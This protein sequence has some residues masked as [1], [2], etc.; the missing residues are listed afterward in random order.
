M[1]R[2]IHPLALLLFTPLFGA[3]CGKI[4][5]GES[6]TADSGET[7]GDI[8]TVA[9][10]FEATYDGTGEEELSDVTLAA[11]G[12]FLVAGHRSEDEFATTSSALFFK[13]D[14]HGVP[15][16]SHT[17][18]GSSSV[19][20]VAVARAAG[21]GAFLAGW[22]FAMGEGSSRD[23]F[24]TR[25]DE[26]GAELWQK[27]YGTDSG[28]EELNGV[29][30]TS[31]GGLLL[32]GTQMTGPTLFDAYV[33]RIDSSGEELF[34]TVLGGDWDDY[35]WDAVEEQDGSFV[36]VGYREDAV[37]AAHKG[38]IFKLDSAGE[39]QWERLHGG[40]NYDYAYSIT[41]TPDGGYAFSGASYS[42]TSEI[43]SDL[44]VVKTDDE[45]RE[46]WHR[47]VDLPFHQY[48]FGVVPDGDGGLVVGGIHLEQGN[49]VWEGLLVG[50]DS[51]GATSWSREVGGD[52][53]DSIYD[54]EV[55]G[56]SGFVAIGYS[57]SYSDPGGLDGWMLRM[58]LD[59]NP[60]SE[61]PEHHELP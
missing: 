30:A 33:V 4:S 40:Q 32:L 52:G 35:A 3:A 57:S 14:P 24:V 25:V 7:T 43:A 2:R 19:Y 28:D 17:V 18:E 22:G 1:N 27:A 10:T 41:A 12:G 56:E 46:L 31:D 36:V 11:D 59:V 61:S 39:L 15:E 29:I 34:S 60:S 51:S 48:G 9:T 21:G 55:V 6:D 8:V 49:E 37:E 26:S 16:W 45:G 38:W 5:A 58:D 47:A 54:L 42:Y 50:L 23:L 44:W 53:K 20:G 13:T